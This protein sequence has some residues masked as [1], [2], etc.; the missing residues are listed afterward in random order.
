MASH[1]RTMC[2]IIVMVNNKVYP[3]G[4]IGSPNKGTSLSALSIIYLAW[5]KEWKY[6]GAIKLSNTC[7]YIWHQP[8]K[9]HNVEWD[10]TLQW[11]C[12]MCTWHCNILMKHQHIFLLPFLHTYGILNYNRHNFQHFVSNPVQFFLKFST[13]SI[14]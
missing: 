12:I 14:A 13:L 2:W 6:L 11:A 5:D 1:V 8:S 3:K 9:G 4:V 7:R 10:P